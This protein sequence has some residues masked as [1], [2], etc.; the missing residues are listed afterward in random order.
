MVGLDES[1]YILCRVDDFNGDGIADR[2]S[3]P[4]LSDRMNI[5][6]YQQPFPKEIQEKASEVVIRENF[7]LDYI[8]RK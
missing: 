6:I 4:R 3:W 5:P 2:I 8:S 7:I 1:S